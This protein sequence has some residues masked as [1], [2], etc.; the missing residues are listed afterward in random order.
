VRMDV[1]AGVTNA[2]IEV[3]EAWMEESRS[4]KIKFNE[5]AYG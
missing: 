4:M 5:M 3:I 2:R 1:S